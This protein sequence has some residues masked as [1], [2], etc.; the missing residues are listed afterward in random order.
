MEEQSYKI[1]IFIKVEKGGGIDFNRC[2]KE[3][4]SLVATIQQE[5][6]DVVLNVEISGS[7]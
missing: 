6:P 2:I 4:V 3:V 7:Y 5:N 1:P